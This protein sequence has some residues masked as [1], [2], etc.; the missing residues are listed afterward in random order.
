MYGSFFVL[1]FS[2]PPFFVCVRVLL[3]GVCRL[4]FVRLC[5]SLF[6]IRFLCLVCCSCFVDGCLWFV[7]MLC[8]VC[9]QLLVTSVLDVCCL[10][11][12]VCWLP[13]VVVRSVL[14]VAC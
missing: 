12:A 7:E 5:R 11:F 3:F 4:W 10:L 14:L 9:S 1:C 2:P 6:V 8:L 13:F